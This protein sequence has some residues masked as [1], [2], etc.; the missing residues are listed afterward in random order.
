MS[1]I[2]LPSGEW[3]DLKMVRIIRTEMLDPGGP[4]CTVMTGKGNLRVFF[5]TLQEASDWMVGFGEV[6]KEFKARASV[7]HSRTGATDDQ[8]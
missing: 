4:C 2:Q 1:L 7:L 5:N 8:A 6:V 3:V